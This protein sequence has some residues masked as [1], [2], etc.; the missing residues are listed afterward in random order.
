MKLD[1]VHDI[2]KSYR[3]VLNCMSRPGLI[4]NIQDCSEKI[5]ME[6][7]FYKA[8]LVLMVM[9]L[10][11]EVSFN[12]VS[13]KQKEITEFVNRLTYAKAS[14]L[15]D[16]DYIFIMSDAEP[17]AIEEAYRRAKPGDLIDPHKSAT[18]IMEA[19]KISNDR[20]LMLK[21]PGIQEA[22]FVRVDSKGNWMEERRNKNTEYPLG[23]DL[24]FV[25]NHS[26]I[27]C[28]PRTTQIFRM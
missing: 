26:N 7:A 10:D 21:G 2:Q 17:Q 12:I 5:D 1:L 19:G 22:S 3:K 13:K 14:G 24:V 6:N 11:A 28:L 8:T 20:E 15:E 16:A 23:I 27:I 4:E 18:I 9:L 25:D